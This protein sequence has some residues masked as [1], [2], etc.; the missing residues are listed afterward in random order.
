MPDMTSQNPAAADLV[1]RSN[2]LGA[3][4]RNTNYVGGNTSAKG[5][6]T[7]SVTGE[8]WNCSGSKAQGATSAR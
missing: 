6:E 3:G 7:D 4:P 8:P 5:T 2:R 1:A